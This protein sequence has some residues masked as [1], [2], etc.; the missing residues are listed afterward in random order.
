MSPSK[1]Q[2]LKGKLKK[3]N[4]LFLYKN[5]QEE[6]N[7]LVTDLSCVRERSGRQVWSRPCRFV[8]FCIVLPLFQKKKGGG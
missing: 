3:P 1:V 8:S 4:V 5:T 7:P 2:N 6:K